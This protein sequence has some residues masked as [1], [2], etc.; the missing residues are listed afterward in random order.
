MYDMAMAER[1]GVPP[2]TRA[3]SPLQ[4]V[5]L[6]IPTSPSLVPL[7]GLTLSMDGMDDAL[8]DLD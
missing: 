6:A 2:V 4:R 1:T 3:C 8:F 7:L 5:V